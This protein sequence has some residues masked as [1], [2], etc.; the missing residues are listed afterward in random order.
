MLLPQHDRPA[1]RV[2]PAGSVAECPPSQDL[3]VEDLPGCGVDLDAAVGADS[4]RHC[5]NSRKVC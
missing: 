1:G 3:D 2:R 5:D 4:H